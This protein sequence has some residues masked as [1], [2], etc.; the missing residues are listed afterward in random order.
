MNIQFTF[1]QMSSSQALSDLFTE[2]L[3]TRIGK[4][5]SRPA[6]AHVT[7]SVMGLQQKIHVSLT[8]ADGRAI[9]A[10]HSGDDMYAE[11]DIVVE[12]LEAQLRKHKERLRNHKRESLKLRSYPRLTELFADNDAIDASDILKLE[13]IRQRRPSVDSVSGL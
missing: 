13:Q 9:E 12:R 6:H 10:E 7:F 2:K 8:T 11:V 4:F 5:T 3:T 1:K